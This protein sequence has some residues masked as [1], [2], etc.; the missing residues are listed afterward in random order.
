MSLT[1]D[2]LTEVVI[3]HLLA[4]Y[5]TCN[6]FTHAQHLA[7]TI[8]APPRNLGNALGKLREAGVI[9]VWGRNGRRYLYELPDDL[10]E[11]VVDSSYYNPAEH[12]EA[13]EIAREAH[14]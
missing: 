11:R 12:D 1:I 8:D 13:L 4:R 2:E 9:D 10:P 14:R 7:A 5:T 6:Q 3:N